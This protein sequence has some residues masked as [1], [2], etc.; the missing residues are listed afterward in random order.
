MA[1][2]TT[3]MA[4]DV[5]PRAAD[6]VLGQPQPLFVT[7]IDPSSVIRNVYSPSPDGKRF[8]VM[9]PLVPQGTSPLVG[10]LNWAAGLGWQ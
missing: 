1:P 3:L 2:D 10:V 7:N 9:S 8:L 5:Q 6:L 4:V